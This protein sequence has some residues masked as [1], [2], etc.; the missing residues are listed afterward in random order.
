M[1]RQA[2]ADSTVNGYVAGKAFKYR[3][4]EKVDGTG[5]VALVF[6]RDGGWSAPDNV[7]TSE[8]P[9]V[10]MR[11]YADPSRNGDGTIKEADAADKAWA[12]YRAANALFHAKRGVRWGPVGSDEGLMVVTAKRWTEPFAVTQD[13]MHGRTARLA[14]AGG[15]G[16][17]NLGDSMY[18]AC[19]Y[20]LHVVH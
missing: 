16:G 20:A 15:S 7:Q 5:G 6:I 14:N 4:E 10:W 18:V 8:Y 2:L 19:Q 12:L 11:C 13:D 9:L 3:L 17:E 1:R